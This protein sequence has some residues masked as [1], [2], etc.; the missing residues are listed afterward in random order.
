MRLFFGS[1]RSRNQRQ[2]RVYHNNGKAKLTDI[3]NF[4][5]Q[6]SIHIPRTVSAIQLKLGMYAYGYQVTKTSWIQSRI[7][8]LH[9]FKMFKSK[10]LKTHT[11]YRKTSWHLFCSPFDSLPHGPTVIIIELGI[12]KQERPDIMA[13]EGKKMIMLWSVNNRRRT[14]LMRCYHSSDNCISY[15]IWEGL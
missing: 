1:K 10:Q 4:V 5:F 9:P 6:L 12:A 14:F 3:H 15:T 7:L 2:N 13:K 8:K 11:L